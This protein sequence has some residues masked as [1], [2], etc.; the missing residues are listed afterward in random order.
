MNLLELVDKRDL[1]LKELEFF[2]SK[3]KNEKRMMNE[4]EDNDFKK[5]INEVE[6]LN[7]LID[8]IKAEDS[9]SVRNE[10]N[11]KNNK[12]IMNNNFSLLK[13]VRDIVEGRNFSEDTLTVLEE[14][15]K[16]FASA[17]MTYRGQL[18]L[19]LEEK[20]ATI[21]TEA[22]GQ[23]G[24]VVAE[25]KKGLLGALRAKTVLGQA[26]ATFY[27]GL[28]GDVSIPVYAGTSCAWATETGTTADGGGAFT[29]VTLTPKRLTTYIDVSKQF[30]VQDGIGAEQSLMQDLVQ[31]IIVKVEN[32]A[33][34]TTASSLSRPAGLFY[35]ATLTGALSGTTS[36]TKIVGVKAA[37]DTS[38]AL[39]GNL[40][41]ITNPT[42]AA[43]W[44]TTST[45]TG[46]GIFCMSN[47]RAAGYPVYVTSN[48]PVLNT[49]YQGVAF[50]NWNDYVVGQW[51]GMDITV[52]PYTQA[53]YGK[54][55]IIV[56]TYWDFKT[57]R[58]ESFKLAQM[59]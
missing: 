50:G 28:V 30:L 20:R 42:L 36:F 58:S 27:T 51:G 38:N 44:E 4:T 17:G 33:F 55:R 46:S 8:D 21:L 49:N 3:V 9:K 15:K 13:A 52:D 23:G 24:Y 10:V 56:N 41:Y 2:D 14:G 6:D 37:V 25:D 5:I 54:V 31:S 48:I 7:K 26:G 19:P 32:T 12:K 1:K 45:D 11:V 18:V 47:G 34:D 22:D 29:E 39:T 43:V 59:S 57:R 16:A 40:A 35:G 53:I